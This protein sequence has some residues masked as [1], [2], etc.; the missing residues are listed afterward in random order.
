MKK[1]A[2]VINRLAL[3]TLLLST[4]SSFADVENSA[5]KK[6]KALGA[7]IEYKEDHYGNRGIMVS[8]GSFWKGGDNGLSHLA[9]VPSLFKL[10][11]GGDITDAGIDH[12]TDIGSIVALDLH[13]LKLTDAGI[14]KLGKMHQ[15]ERLNLTYTQVTDQGLQKLS[16]LKNLKWLGLAYT[17]VSK[18][19]VNR[20]KRQLHNTKI[21]GRFKP[22]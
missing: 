20:L 11:L 21:E 16:T 12:I 22:G 5:I 17:Q 3:L 1:I 4:A 8:I 14:A 6:L 19:A 15:L 13:L 2:A 18:P 7:A 9:E 10:R